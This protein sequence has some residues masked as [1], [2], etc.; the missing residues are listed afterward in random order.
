MIGSD[1]P[2]PL[3]EANAGDVD[4]QLAAA[5]P[6]PSADLLLPTTR[7]RYLGLGVRA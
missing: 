2:Y 7:R 1:Y 4:P 3:G 6:T 5:R